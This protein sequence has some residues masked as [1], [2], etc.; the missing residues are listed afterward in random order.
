LVEAAGRREGAMGKCIVLFSDGT[1]NSSAKAQK[2]NVWRLF[3]A[4]DQ[5]ESSL[6]AMYDDGV[7]TSSNKYLAALGGAFGFG[8]KRNV[9]DLYK[10]VCRN[11]NE[12]D[13]I[14]GFGFSRGA[15]TIRVLVGLIAREGLVPFTTEEELDRNARSAYRDYRSKAFPS[16]SPVVIGLRW[17]RDGILR[18]K[19]WIRGEPTYV[20]VSAQTQAQGRR[21][22]R[23]RF[24]GL[25]DT[26]EAYGIPIAELK[27]GIDWVLWPMLFGDYTL[28]KM[29]DRACHALS[30]D[31]ARTTFHP[32][33]WDE[34]AEA[35]MVKRNEVPAGR[36]TQVWFAGVHCNVGGG[37]PED[38]LSLV[39][40]EWIMS[41]AKANELPLDDA[42]IQS[43]A[44]ASSPYARLYDSRAGLAS[45]FRYGPRSIP[46]YD[47]HPDILPM[48]HGSVI[49]RMGRGSDQYAP[50][51]LPHK[52]WVVAPDGEL[53][54]MTAADDAL[55]LDDTKRKM[56]MAAPATKSEQD[57]ADEKAALQD[58]MAAD[59]ARPDREAVGLVWDTVWW[60][61]LFYA[62]T[63]ALTAVVAAYPF[64]GGFLSTKVVELVGHIPVFGDDLARH[65]K[66]VVGVGDVGTGGFISPMVDAASAFIPS[67]ATPW[68]KTLLKY[69]IEFSSIVIAILLLMYGSAILQ[70]RIHDRARLAWHA[71]LLPQYRQ[72]LID[73]ET[74]AS[75]ML[76]AGFVIALLLMI[77]LIVCGTDGLAAVELGVIAAILALILVLRLLERRRL[78]SFK[79]D[80]YKMHSTGA[81]R[82]A[83]TLRT[84]AILVFLYRAL[85]KF[86]VPIAFAVLLFI[87]GAALIN[88]VT[89]DA[90]SAAGQVCKTSVP[91][92]AP[93]VDKSATAT[94]FTTDKICWPSGLV[95]ESGKRYRI[96]LT[97]TADDWKDGDT[98]STING[99]APDSVNHWIGILLRR[100]WTQNWFK[101]IAHIGV[102]G[103]Y[104]YV[105]KPLDSDSTAPNGDRTLVSEVVPGTDGELFIYVND[106]VLM[107][108]GWIDH[109]YKH[110]NQG[111]ASL[112]VDLVR[113]N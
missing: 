14:Y 91:A 106:A 53:L 78:Q 7:G 21:A 48:V 77:V 103:N 52:F 43:A 16:W 74:S 85:C 36:I 38:R 18:A 17:L 97:M 67:Y 32:L 107:F 47:E 112:K 56:A 15:F 28:S 65:L 104:E 63:V 95:L 11:W 42:H 86:L 66:A 71:D 31:D 90:W 44:A 109:F 12:G 49:M 3:Q 61:R 4:I 10:F 59:L 58:V 83:R 37:Y 68:I 39:P 2:T 84:N 35:E 19:N 69:P 34:A 62:L 70:S 23:I 72:S 81:L 89:F 1:G 46:K 13:K 102:F 101:P 55:S 57:V 99:F 79:A 33:L 105:L 41:E 51:I 73:M 20:K 24:L 25:W 26:V 50:I 29:V 54:P 94:G 22:V 93:K 92:N 30:L 40:L 6:L 9:I 76:G 82:F 100:W 96:T 8:L 27:R 111:G 113:Q 87:V 110:N 45:Y 88:R 80:T 5:R 75:R 64:T 60:R 98:P 108:P